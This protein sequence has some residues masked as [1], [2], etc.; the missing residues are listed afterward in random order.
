MN[1]YRI[2]VNTGTA[3]LATFDVQAFN[4]QEAVDKV[5]DLIEEKHEG[6]FND[7][8]ALQDLCE[9]GQTVDEYAEANNLTCCGNH[10]IYISIDSITRLEHDPNC[11]FLDE[12]M[13]EY[14]DTLPTGLECIDFYCDRDLS[15]YIDSML[16][17]SDDDPIAFGEFKMRGKDEI[18]NIEL[19]VNGEVR[20]NY[21]G[22]TYTCPYDFPEELKERIRRNPD[23]W[24]TYAS[25][26]EGN[27]DECGDIHVIMNNWYEYLIGQKKGDINVF[28]DGVMYEADLS[29]DTPIGVFK[30][31]IDIAYDFLND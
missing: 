5:A 1:W 2:L 20:L 6:L 23:G 26:G 18:F 9:T 10:G 17:D 7:H 11:V 25:S 14:A 24:S 31:M 8:Y 3:Y 16:F 22:S 27:D 19:V 12:I 21:K 15:K 28:Y 13:N 4:E 30:K 29:K